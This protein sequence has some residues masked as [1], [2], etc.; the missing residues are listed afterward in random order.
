V[1]H[2]HWVGLGTGTPKD[3]DKVNNWDVCECDGW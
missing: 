3:R 2:I 1:S